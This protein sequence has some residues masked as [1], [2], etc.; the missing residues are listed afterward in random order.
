SEGAEVGGKPLEAFRQDSQ[1]VCLV[2][3]ATRLKLFNDPISDS[4]SLVAHRRTLLHLL[5]LGLPDGGS[6]V[7]CQIRSDAATDFDVV[8]SDAADLFGAFFRGH[9]SDSHSLT[10]SLCRP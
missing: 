4:Q 10:C 2:G 5:G 3:I 8:A 1:P 7:H 6:D 9:K